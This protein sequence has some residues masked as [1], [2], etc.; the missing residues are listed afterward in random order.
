VVCRRAS[1]GAA[2]YPT[3]RPTACHCSHRSGNEHFPNILE[4][5]VTTASPRPFA[6]CWWKAFAPGPLAP[7]I[8]KGCSAASRC[9]LGDNGEAIVS[10]RQLSMSRSSGLRADGFCLHC[11]DASDT[12]C[13]RRCRFG[14]RSCLLGARD[15]QVFIRIYTCQRR[16]ASDGYVF[17]PSA[18]HVIASTFVS[19]VDT[20]A[21]L[22][23][24]VVITCINFDRLAAPRES[25][26]SGRTT[27]VVTAEVS[28]LLL[29]LPHLNHDVFLLHIRTISYLHLTR[30]VHP[31]LL[32]LALERPT[33]L[34]DLASCAPLLTSPPA[35]H[36]QHRYPHQLQT[37]S[38]YFSLH[39]G[40]IK[41][42]LIRASLFPTYR[43]APS[44]GIIHLSLEPTSKRRICARQLGRL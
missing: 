23:P 7:G 27:S 6:Q 33:V 11:R 40:N 34:A 42:S 20:R 14:E 15:F 22:Q 30:T 10:L 38:P 5:A 18:K 25:F 13:P 17:A 21:G 24:S 37:A 32:S 41:T 9:V 43:Y 26:T 2:E 29:P 44:N 4:T 31:P 3:G 35:P 16:E 36:S 8:P 19:Y 28:P 1:S 12:V 39:A